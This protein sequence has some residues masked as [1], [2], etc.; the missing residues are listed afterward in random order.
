MAKNVDP[1]APKSKAVET[2]LSLVEIGPRFVMTPIVILEGSFGGPVIY[3]NKE[4]V[5]P[6]AIRADIRNRKAQKYHAR[7]QEKTKREVKMKVLGIEEGREKGELDDD[8]LF[9]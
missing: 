3:E 5:S 6:N 8:V 9:A 2:E 1:D 7:T 4:F